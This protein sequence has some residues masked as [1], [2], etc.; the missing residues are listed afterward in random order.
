[1]TDIRFTKEQN[2]ALVQ[3]LQAY[4]DEELDQDL[5]QFEAEFLLDFISDEI[6]AYFYNQGLRDARAVM[7]NK[8]EAIAD[9]LYEIEKA[10]S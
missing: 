1:M 2:E 4:F 8:L 3:K 10:E 6:G 7:E 9:T 5:G